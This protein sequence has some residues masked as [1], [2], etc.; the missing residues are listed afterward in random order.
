MNKMEEIEDMDINP[1]E[2]SVRKMA[3]QASAT[4][5]KL[6]MSKSKAKHKAA[7]ASKVKP[8]TEILENNI[9]KLDAEN[10]KDIAALEE[11]R[12]E[13]M[14]VVKG[15]AGQKVKASQKKIDGLRAKQGELKNKAK[16]QKGDEKKATLKEAGETFAELRHEE[17]E[18]AGSDEFKEF[19]QATVAV[20][21]IDAQ[22]SNKESVRDQ[23]AG[24]RN[25]IEAAKEISKKNPELKDFDS[26]RSIQ[27]FNNFVKKHEDK[28]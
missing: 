6:P 5:K 26:L 7:A 12:G 2:K 27:D 16:G 28:K 1:V 18:L 8:S 4:L 13:A 3:Q 11:S 14:A 19:Q 22:I 10:D 20:H 9:E 24:T 21:Q 15:A 17:R 25:T 23:Y